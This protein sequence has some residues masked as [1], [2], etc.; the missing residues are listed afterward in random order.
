[1]NVAKKVVH[2]KIESQI[3]I[4][5]AKLETLKAKAEAGKANAELKAITDLLTRKRAIEQELDQ[6]KQTGEAKWEQAK[7]N[8]E[9]RMSELEQSV[10]ALE[11]KLITA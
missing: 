11:G 10:R 1:M 3:K 9:S 8:V 4:A 2:D 7:T 5:Q 6:L